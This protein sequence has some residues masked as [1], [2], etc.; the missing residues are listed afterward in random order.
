[1]DDKYDFG[2]EYAQ[3]YKEKCKCGNEIEVSTQTDSYPEY[4]AGVFV[5]CPCGESVGFELP[6][7]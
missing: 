5:R 2:S 3:T 7:N 4:T 1:M 6:V